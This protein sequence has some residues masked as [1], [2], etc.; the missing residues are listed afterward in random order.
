MNEKL[1]TSFLGLSLLFMVLPGVIPAEGQ[2]FNDPCSY[3]YYSYSETETGQKVNKGWMDS[4]KN[5]LLPWRNSEQTMPV[6]RHQPRRNSFTPEKTRAEQPDP[7][8]P[9]ETG[10]ELKLRIGQLADQLLTG[11][12][13]FLTAEEPKVVVTTF[14]D[15]NHLYKT[16]DLG[17]LIAE[18][19][20]GELQSRGVAVLD[21]RMANSLQIKQGYGIYG[22]SRDMAELSYVHSAQARLVGTYS[23]ADGQVVINARVLHQED[24]R[25]L[26]SGTIILEENRLIARL[27]DDSGWPAVDD[28]R[29]MV[30][31]FD[32]IKLSD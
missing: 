4:L 25:V 19:M 22:L 31:S 1:T 13:N 23:I 3:A 32:N 27:L 7:L 6:T 5:L 29:V 12:G 8:I 15:L 20:I 17:R 16:T 9:N 2:F 11:D 14:V 10:T 24:G 18:Q 21:V 26:T 28:R 30:E